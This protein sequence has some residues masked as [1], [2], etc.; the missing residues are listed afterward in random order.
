MSDQASIRKFTDSADAGVVS[1]VA[2]I[3]VPVCD[4]CW[5]AANPWWIGFVTLLGLVFISA[6]PFAIAQDKHVNIPKFISI[7]LLIVI[8]AAVG[9]ALMA[10]RRA[11]VRLVP[12]KID[13]E[14]LRITFFDKNYAEAFLEANKPTAKL[15]NPWKWE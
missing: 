7:L 1:V 14:N 8:F 10:R 9:C 15:I 6:I 4:K 11:P 13:R 5:K 3:E 12:N 2:T